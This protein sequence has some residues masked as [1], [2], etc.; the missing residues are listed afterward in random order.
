MKIIYFLKSQIKKYMES[1]YFFKY[2]I[3]LKRYCQDINLV[4]EEDTVHNYV[5]W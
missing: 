5:Y 1:V 3:T 2:Q 4:F